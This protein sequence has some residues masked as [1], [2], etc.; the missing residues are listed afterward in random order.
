MRIFFYV[1]KDYL[2][3]VAGALVLSLFLFI[4]FDFI[5][6]TTKYFARYKPTAEHVFQ[7]Y[8]FQ[9][10]AHLIQALPIA[11]LLASVISMVLLARTNEVTAMRAAGMGPV[12]VGAPLAFGGIVLGVLGLLTSEFVLPKTASKVHYIQSV[13]IEGEANSETSQGVRWARNGS[14]LFNFGDYD[15][16]TQ[17]LS[18]VKIVEMQPSFRPD[19]I[20]EAKSAQYLP[21]GKTW[22]LEN[23]KTTYFLP[24]GTVEYVDYKASV[25][26]KLP[27]EPSKL[28]KERRMD[29]ELSVRELLDR[30]SRA[31]KSGGDSI[32]TKV[33]LHTKVAYPFAAFVVALIGIKFGYRSERTTETAKGILLALAIGMSYWLI[34][35]AMTA[36]GNRG[37]VPPVVA[38]WTAN[39]V[40]GSIAA[41]EIWRARKG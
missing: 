32:T 34:L 4:L 30:V 41:I 18:R 19:Q 17:T 36:L 6:K 25:N 29:S 20:M 5:H 27:I 21:E 40:I 15:S 2:R 9:I 8:W 35:N 37:D 31:E 38:A 14:S 11:S 1:L 39:F 23:V 22:R 3:Y 7:Y 13:K 33:D 16:S 24:A 12:S 26:S 10:P 28:Q